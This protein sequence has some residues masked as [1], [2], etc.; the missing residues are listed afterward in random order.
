M[1][2]LVTPT[3]ILEGVTLLFTVGGVVNRH[4]ATP[5]ALPVSIRTLQ[6]TTGLLID[7]TSPGNPPSLEKELLSSRESEGRTR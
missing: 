3:D 1:V 2:I 5:D 6:S 4:F 7:T